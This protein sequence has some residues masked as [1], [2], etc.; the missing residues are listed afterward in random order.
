[1]LCVIFVSQGVFTWGR[2]LLLLT[3][4]SQVGGGCSLPAE[5]RAV[6][7]VQDFIGACRFLF[8]MLAG[9]DEEFK[10]RGSNFLSW[11]LGVLVTLGVLS[12][13][14]FAIHFPCGRPEGVKVIYFLLLSCIY[15]PLP[16]SLPAAPLMFPK[17]LKSFIFYLC[18]WQW[19]CTLEDFV[20]SLLGFVGSALGM[21]ENK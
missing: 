7:V 3:K 1:M 21:W 8:I 10:R 13:L 15:F 12:S 20:W 9:S 14:V 17:H 18:L 6:V 5:A 4:L 16:A 19:Y 2:R 11:K